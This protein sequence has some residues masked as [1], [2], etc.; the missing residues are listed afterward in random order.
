MLSTSKP[1]CRIASRVRQTNGLKVTPLAAD[2][3]LWD[4]LN[5]GFDLFGG[6]GRDSRLYPLAA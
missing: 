3:P 2:D 4:W 6:V 1:L 5:R